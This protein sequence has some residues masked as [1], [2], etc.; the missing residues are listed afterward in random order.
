MAELAIGRACPHDG[1]LTA[2]A[3]SKTDRV[4]V[5]VCACCGRTVQ[6]ANHFFAGD[7]A[8]A[9]A[10]LEAVAAAEPITPTAA[11]DL[12]EDARADEGEPDENE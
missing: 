6:Q 1:T 8:E 5:G 9:V 3:G 2:C 10:E 12:A 4:L 11:F 7:P